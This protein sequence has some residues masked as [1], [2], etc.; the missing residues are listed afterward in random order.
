MKKVSKPEGCI[1]Y[2]F[3]LPFSLSSQKGEEQNNGTFLLWDFHVR[4]S[5]Y[6]ERVF[7]DDPKK[8]YLKIACCKM[9][10]NSSFLIGTVFPPPHF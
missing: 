4:E 9:N 1:I 3:K 6:L 5:P 8:K 7:E 10:I 2:L